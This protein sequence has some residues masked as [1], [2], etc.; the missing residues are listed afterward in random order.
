LGPTHQATAQK[1]VEKWNAFQNGMH[2]ISERAQ[3][4]AAR[5]LKRAL[6]RRLQRVGLEWADVEPYVEQIDS[7]K[8]IQEFFL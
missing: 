7:M 2:F 1:V 4:R 3:N 6:E 8:E 5:K